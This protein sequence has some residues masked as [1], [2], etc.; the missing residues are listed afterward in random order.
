M[1]PGS[2]RRPWRQPRQ[3]GT[4]RRR[5]A[6]L[7]Q[8]HG[9][10]LGKPS[11]W[12]SLGLF[13]RQTISPILMA[14]QISAKHFALALLPLALAAC[15]D[16]ASYR[17]T[18]VDAAERDSSGRADLDSWP[19]ADAELTDSMVDQSLVDQS[20]V[21]QSPILD[22]SPPDQ[23]IPDLPACTTPCVFT[24]NNALA[25]CKWLTPSNIPLS[26]LNSL[27][28]TLLP[29]AIPTGTTTI[30][31]DDGTIRGP[32]GTIQGIYWKTISQVSGGKL[33]L[34]V[35][36]SLNVRISPLERILNA[37][38]RMCSY[39]AQGGAHG[40]T[41]TR[42]MDDRDGP[43]RDRGLAPERIVDGG[44]LPAARDPDGEVLLVEAA[45]RRSRSP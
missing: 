4:P 45:A 24:C 37:R 7:R 29:L 31:S 33:S 23:S 28:T 18:Q 38:D 35:I 9:L 2:C 11:S 3:S 42:E 13:A 21:D 34:F 6:P 19:S 12:N 26:E 36:S 1:A 22:Q 14:L 32:A 16:L 17:S 30:N 20:L 43:G 5:Q 10:H 25:R 8:T 40:E 27:S 39:G 41:K 15:H 44:A